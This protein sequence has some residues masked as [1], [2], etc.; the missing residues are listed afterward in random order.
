[1]GMIFT[2]KKGSSQ[3]MFRKREL[4]GYYDDS[5]MKS[6]SVRENPARPKAVELFLYS[7]LTSQAAI[8]RISFHRYP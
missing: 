5:Y 1:M 8:T 7:S 6:A 2:E 3:S 4:Y